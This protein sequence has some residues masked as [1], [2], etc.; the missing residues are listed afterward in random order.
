MKKIYIFLA[1]VCLIALCAS[2]FAGPGVNDW[3]VELSNDYQ[4]VCTSPGRIY[5]CK[6][7][8]FVLDGI[9]EDYCCNERFL[10]LKVDCFST[11]ST[12][13]FSEGYIYL[14]L[15]DMQEDAVYG[16]YKESEYQQQLKDLQILDLG[17]WSQGDG[18]PG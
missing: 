6:E 16:P 17:E 9:V 12:L 3:T 10:G 5:L 8:S 1:L 14:Y 4:I 11:Q 15:V 13:D 2:C 18:S 7:N